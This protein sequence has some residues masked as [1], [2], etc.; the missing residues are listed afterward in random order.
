MAQ[1]R[2]ASG[3]AP[4][5]RRLV[6]VFGDQLDETSAAFDEF[7]PQRDRVW[8]A[9]V[10]RE[11]SHGWCHRQR[12]VFFLSAMRH[13]RDRLR[14]KGWTVEYTELPPRRSEDRAP[15][16]AGL[17]A[18]DLKRLRPES[19]VWVRPGDWRVREAV[20]RAV[21][22]AGLEL[23]E[24]AD[25]HFYCR[26]EEF[27]EYATGR[28]L[29]L[30]YFYRW[31]R[32]REGI[33]MDRAG[34]P[35]GGRWNY[36][37]DNRETF[38]KSGPGRVPPVPRCRPDGLTREVME[39]V[40]ARFPD[41]PGTLDGF[42]WP[43]TREEARKALDDFLENRLGGFGRYEDAIWEGEP[44]LFHSRLSPL[45]NVKLLNPREAVEGALEAYEKKRAPLNSVEGF[46]RQILGWREFVRGIYWTRMPDYAGHNHLGAELAVPAFFWNGETEMACVRSAMND[47][48][49][50]GWLHHIRRLM[51]LGLLAQLLG[52]H[53]RAFH[54][55]HL[56]MYL[57]AV[58]W[59]SLP[60]ALGMSQFGD[61]GIVG[62]KP[63]C[64]SGKYI[65]RMSNH[66]AG[67]RF[68]PAEA[69]GENACP[70][71]T[72]Y[73]DFLDRHRKLWAKNRRMVFQLKNLERKPDRELAA[74]RHGAERLREAWGGRY[75]PA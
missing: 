24:R 63:Y 46:V 55:W 13:F 32:K 72:L 30:E 18:L 67:C 2:S 65:Q 70:F 37:A 50:E 9:E 23:E 68:D 33:L 42:D 38:G 3:P 74:I 6:L 69:L 66:C 31:L 58:D 47:L 20:K 15:D 39:L 12:I 8:M 56:A 44:V 21:A 49:R 62:T 29:M 22:E 53:P 73:W 71:T 64:A 51:V 11:T 25:R 27:E 40:G 48:L 54:E 36:D 10:D 34:K 19:V 1:P 60:N 61:G 52:V 43:V 59:V 4:K 5:C 35:V 28:T 7:D 41:H 14:E 26:V 57:D 75:E 16:H 45:L 17:L